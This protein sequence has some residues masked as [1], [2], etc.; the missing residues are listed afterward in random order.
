[1]GKNVTQRLN[2]MED[3]YAAHEMPRL[4]K[5]KNTEDKDL[6]DRMTKR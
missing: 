3:F 4:A 1:M 2:I 5:T 6:Y